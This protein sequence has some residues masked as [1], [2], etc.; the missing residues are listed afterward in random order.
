[1]PVD[2]Y[3]SMIPVDYSASTAYG[4]GIISLGPWHSFEIGCAG[5]TVLFCRYFSLRIMS[6]ASWRT[7]VLPNDNAET[8]CLV[9]TGGFAR[10]YYSL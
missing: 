10:A 9:T 6:G 3:L 4:S 2:G 1:M 5:L 8:R 7:R